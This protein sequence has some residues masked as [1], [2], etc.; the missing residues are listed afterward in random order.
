MFRTPGLDSLRIEGRGPDGN[1][2]VCADGRPPSRRDRLAGGDDLPHR[3]PGPRVPEERGDVPERVPAGAHGA[4][5]PEAGRDVDR[6][7]RGKRYRKGL[8][9]ARVVLRPLDDRGGT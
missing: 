6:P 7:S 1:V 4:A 5:V 9:P 8:L 3:G 2:S